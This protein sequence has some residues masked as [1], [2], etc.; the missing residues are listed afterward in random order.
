MEELIN[1]IYKELLFLFFE[2]FFIFARCPSNVMS[3]DEGNKEDAVVLF[4]LLE[5]IFYWHC[6]YFHSRPIWLLLFG[7]RKG[8][9][10]PLLYCTAGS[11]SD[12]ECKT[13]KRDQNC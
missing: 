10:L 11:L 2:W 6:K 4:L 1:D 13:N 9:L 3:K 7:G 8:K 5:E 12:L